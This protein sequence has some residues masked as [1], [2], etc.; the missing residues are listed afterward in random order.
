MRQLQLHFVSLD[1]FGVRL[2][3][4]IRDRRETLPGIQSVPIDWRTGIDPLDH[5]RDDPIRLPRSRIVRRHAI[6]EHL[7]RGVTIHTVVRTKGLLLGAVDLRLLHQLGYNEQGERRAF[8]SLMLFDF[9]S[10]AASS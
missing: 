8:A 9:S 3:R 1:E 5:I 4:H 6:P 7:E 2:R 10:V